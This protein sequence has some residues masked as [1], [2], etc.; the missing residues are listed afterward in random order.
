MC[1]APS[2][3]IAILITVAQRDSGPYLRRPIHRYPPTL[4]P[5]YAPTLAPTRLTSE[6][7]ESGVE[8]SDVE[9]TGWEANVEGGDFL[10]DDQYPC[11]DPRREVCGVEEDVYA[12][13]E[14]GEGG[15]DVDN[16]QSDCMKNDDEEVPPPAGPIMGAV[17]YFGAGPI[18]STPVA[19]G[20]L[21]RSDTERLM[22][23]GSSALGNEQPDRLP[24]NIGAK[25]KR[26]ANDDG[27]DEPTKEVPVVPGTPLHTRMSDAALQEAYA[28]STKH[29]HQK[30]MLEDFGCRVFPG[31]PQPEQWCCHFCP[32]AL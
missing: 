31:Q 4:L 23:E 16:G 7:D 17:H 5:F 28:G 2:S 32:Y 11:V 6:H 29:P 10:V 14:A 19:Q 24:S 25:R 21:Q 9:D 27:S 20:T 22:N 3:G 15:P 13:A 18:R 30:Q 12:D 8:V 26:D 1:P